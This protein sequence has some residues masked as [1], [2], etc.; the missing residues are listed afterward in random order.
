MTSPFVTYRDK[1]LGYYGTASWLRKL[2]LS[3]WN[4]TD[5]Q[6]G[7]SNLASVDDEHYAAA[8]AMIQSYRHNGERD[9]EFMTL[10]E[11]CQQRAEAEKAASRRSA[12]FDSWCQE[13]QFDL[14]RASQRASYIEDHYTWFEQ[15][16][17][18]GV[19]PAIAAAQA[20][21]SNLDGKAATRT[22]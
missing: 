15:Q 19:E 4:G 17:D 22:D 6:V 2:V 5:Y 21:A 18:D 8:L 12:R 20:L 13:V 10:A 11:A 7:L 14:R 1:V 9:P 16:F 3:M